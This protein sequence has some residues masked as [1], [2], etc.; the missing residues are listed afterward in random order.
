[1]KS[2][3]ESIGIQINE[4]EIAS[5]STQDFTSLI[6]KKIQET[7]FQYLEQIK[8]EHRKVRENN[9]LSFDKP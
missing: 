5:T 8:S 7:A 3:F 9:Y 4:E 6:K 2:D 1:M